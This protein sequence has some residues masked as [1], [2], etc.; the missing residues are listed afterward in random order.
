MKKYKN[1]KAVKARRCKA[2]CETYGSMK[3]V[4]IGIK[5]PC[6]TTCGGYCCK[7]TE[8]DYKRSVKTNDSKRTR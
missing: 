5:E 2:F 1:V 7:C 4:C 3:N 8:Y 6:E